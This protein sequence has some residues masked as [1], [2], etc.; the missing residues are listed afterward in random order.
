MVRHSAWHNLIGGRV[1]PNTPHRPWRELRPVGVIIVLC[2]LQRSYS[3]RAN[4]WSNPPPRRNI[5]PWQE[6]P[7]AENLHNYGVAP[8][9]QIPVARTV[10]F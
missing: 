9:P 3:W 10:D 6:R 5:T 4:S 8:D 1:D 2:Q 7:C